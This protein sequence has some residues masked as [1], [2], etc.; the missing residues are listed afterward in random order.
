VDVLDVSNPSRPRLRGS[1]KLPI[2]PEEVSVSANGLICALDGLSG[3]WFL[4]Y[5]PQVP[6]APS[7]LTAS[8]RSWNKVQLSFQDNSQYDDGPK[9]ERRVT[10]TGLWAETTITVTTIPIAGYGYSTEYYDLNVRAGIP[11]EYRLRAYNSTGYS[12]YSNVASAIVPD[13]TPAAPRFRLLRHDSPSLLL[14]WDDTSNNEEGFRIER[15]TGFTGTWQQVVTAAPNTSEYGL[16]EGGLTTGT[17]YLFRVVAYNPRGTAYSN[18]ISYL[19]A[20][21]PPAAPSNLTA[22]AIS[23]TQAELHWRDNSNNEGGFRIDLG[24][25]NYVLPN[26]TSCVVGGL[27]PGMSYFVRV[28]AYNSAGETWS[29]QVRM[30]MP[31]R[32]TATARAWS[33]YE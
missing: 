11:Y 26:T 1:Y 21:I 17:L 24:G 23:P 28:F 20:A 14:I 22:S 31:P 3:P 13:A 25:G 32:S 29:E 6:A 5:T 30:Q 9:L 7:K 2:S 33:Q 18:E 4:R 19:Q 27:M 16:P 8:A 12:S 10:P 15:K